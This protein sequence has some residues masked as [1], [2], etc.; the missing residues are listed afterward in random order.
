MKALSKSECLCIDA[1]WFHI[2]YFVYEVCF[3]IN[4]MHDIGTLIYVTPT[5]HIESCVD[6]QHVLSESNTNSCD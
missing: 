4:A 5:L 2:E 6:A 3:I 1:H